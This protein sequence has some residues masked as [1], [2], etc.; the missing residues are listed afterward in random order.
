MIALAK[1][2]QE[3]I[4]FSFQEDYQKLIDSKKRIY[5]P[6][7]RDEAHKLIEQIKMVIKFENYFEDESINTL[8]DLIKM[9]KQKFRLR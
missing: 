5:S 8:Y 2:D 7:K 9:I 4:I 1:K 3:N 6:T